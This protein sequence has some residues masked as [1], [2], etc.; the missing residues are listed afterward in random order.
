MFFDRVVCGYT[1]SLA[2]IKGNENL[3]TRK[4]YYCSKKSDLRTVY[5]AWKVSKLELGMVYEDLLCRV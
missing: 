2:K 4:I 3:L 5:H 1:T